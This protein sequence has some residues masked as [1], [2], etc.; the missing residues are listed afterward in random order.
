MQFPFGK[1]PQVPFATTC[2]VRRSCSTGISLLLLGLA[3]AACQVGPLG[4]QEAEK[5]AVIAAS[6]RF[7]RAE[8]L[9]DP[10]SIRAILWEDAVLQPSDGRRIEGHEAILAFYG[11]RAGGG[12]AAPT[13]SASA[14]TSPTAPAPDPTPP[15]SPSG[16]VISP[17]GDMAVEWGPGQIRT[18]RGYYSYNFMSIWE[19]RTGEWKLLV[20]AWNTRPA[21]VTA[22]SAD[23]TGQSN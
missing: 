23:T 2:H 19:R 8:R 21:P 15:K 18:K 6:R 1:E 3:L 10:D 11:F 9:H 17:T 4:A 7:S 12:G 5:A 20:N 13:A 22:P 16:L 14:A